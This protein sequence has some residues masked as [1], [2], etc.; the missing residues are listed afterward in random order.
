MQSKTVNSMQYAVSQF[1][2]PVLRGGPS[3]IFFQKTRHLHSKNVH[4]HA[5]KR[6]MKHASLIIFQSKIQMHEIKVNEML[7]VLWPA[8]ERNKIPN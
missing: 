7:K 2:L 1:P 6:S 5:E 8:W 3:N 4:R